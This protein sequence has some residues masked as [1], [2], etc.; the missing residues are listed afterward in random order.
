MLLL[1]ALPAVVGA[2]SELPPRLLC[3]GEVPCVFLLPVWAGCFDFSEIGMRVPL[4]GFFLVEA[5]FVAGGV[6]GF[7]FVVA[8]VFGCHCS[9]TVGGKSCKEWRRRSC[10]PY[11]CGRDPLEH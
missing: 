10:M 1:Q 5:L 8:G 3:F 9:E 6:L 4:D 2:L 7:L 11:E